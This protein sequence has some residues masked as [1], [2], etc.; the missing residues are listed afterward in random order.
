MSQPAARAGWHITTG[1]TRRRGWRRGGW[2]GAVDGTRAGGQVGPAVE[3]PDRLASL[4]HQAEILPAVTAG[5]Q[6]QEH[7]RGSTDDAPLAV[8]ITHQD[9]RL[10]ALVR[11]VAGGVMIKRDRLLHAVTIEVAEADLRASPMA[12]LVQH[13]AV[14]HRHAGRC[15]ELQRVRRRNRWRARGIGRAQRQQRHQQSADHREYAPQGAPRRSAAGTEPDRRWNEQL[16]RRRD[17]R[18]N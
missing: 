13:V 4:R 10:V 17:D 16:P 5:W 1:G 14:L 8:A 7:A 18:Q 3:P 12:A 2:R 6:R 15:G 11:T 9:L